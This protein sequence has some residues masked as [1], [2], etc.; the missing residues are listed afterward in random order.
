MYFKYYLQIGFKYDY[1]RLFVTQ[2][3]SACNKKVAKLTLRFIRENAHWYIECIIYSC[4]K[5]LNS[6]DFVDED[7]MIECSCQL[8]YKLIKINGS[9]IDRK[10]VLNVK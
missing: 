2:E 8:F 9:Y 10:T 3:C 4:G 1:K 7:M 5:N 6:N